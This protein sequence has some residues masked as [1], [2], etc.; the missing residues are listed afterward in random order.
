MTDVL[1]DELTRASDLLGRLR[2]EL[3]KVVLG[4]DAA[5]EQVLITILCGGHAPA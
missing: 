4:Q 5:I 2:A 1:P 3:G